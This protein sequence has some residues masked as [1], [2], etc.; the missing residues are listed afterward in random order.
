MPA[1]GFPR[2]SDPVLVAREKR[3]Y[4]ETALVR[5]RLDEP[6]LHLECRSILEIIERAEL[7]ERDAKRAEVAHALNAAEARLGVVS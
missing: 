5:H 3:L 4:Y 1:V 6:G 7:E 2:F